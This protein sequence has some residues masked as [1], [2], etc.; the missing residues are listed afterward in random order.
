MVTGPLST[1]KL[2]TQVNN[3][4]INRPYKTDLVPNTTHEFTSYVAQY[5]ARMDNIEHSSPGAPLV[6]YERYYNN[7]CIGYFR[8]VK[9]LKMHF[10]IKYLV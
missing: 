5:F 8:K 2:I 7:K 6:R 10:N 3:S 9:L 4:L 1:T